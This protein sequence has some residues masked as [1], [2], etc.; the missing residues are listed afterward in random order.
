MKWEGVINCCLRKMASQQYS[1]SVYSIYF[2]IDI[3]FETRTKDS[4]E[5][6]CR[7]AYVNTNKIFY[8]TS[9]LIWHTKC[10]YYAGQWHYVNI[11]IFIFQMSCLIKKHILD[12]RVPEQVKQLVSSTYLDWSLNQISCLCFLLT[13]LE[14]IYDFTK[15]IKM[16]ENI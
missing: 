10:W 3:N 5:L 14:H 1:M 16:P 15:A 2:G 8:R 6:N 9:V 7:M 13:R 11:Y 4:A 12:Y